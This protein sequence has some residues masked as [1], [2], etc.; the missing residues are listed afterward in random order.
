MERDFVALVD[1][2][3]LVGAVMARLKP[4]PDKAQNAKAGFSTALRMT[5]KYKSKSKSGSFDYAQDDKQIQKQKQKQVLRL[6]SG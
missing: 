2:K 4:C 6:R 5:S 3:K 1:L